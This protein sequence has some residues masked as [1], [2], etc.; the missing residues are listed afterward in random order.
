MGI[1]TREITTEDWKDIEGQLKDFYTKVD[2]LIDGYKVTLM[3]QRIS[4][5]QNAIVPYVNGVVKGKW[6]T[7]DCEERRRFLRP[8]T[9]SLLSAKKMRELKLS[10]KI[11]KEYKEKM[12]YTT[13]SLYWPSFKPLKRHLI[14]NNQV[15]ELIVTEG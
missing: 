9:R 1:E 3:L 14:R 13:F 11:L 8:V 15:I 2:L 6:L 4:V 10:K 5:T 12:K 7:E